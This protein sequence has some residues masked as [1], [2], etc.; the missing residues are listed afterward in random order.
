M[1]ATNKQILLLF[2]EELME[3]E[4]DSTTYLIGLSVS[5]WPHRYSELPCLH[6][7]GLLKGGLNYFAKHADSQSFEKITRLN[8]ASFEHVYAS[9]LPLWTSRSLR[10][11]IHRLINPRLDCRAFTGRGCLVL[12]L[13][14]LSHPNDLSALAMM[15]GNSI[16]TISNYVRWGVLILSEAMED[17]PEASLTCSLEHLQILGEKAG[18]TYG[19]VMRGCCIVTDGSLHPLERDADAQWAYLDYDHDHPDYNGWKSCYCKKGLYFFAIDG[20]IVWSCIDCPGRWHDGLI[21]DRSAS[22]LQALPAGLWV[23][24]DS[25]FPRIAGK[26]ARSRKRNEH[27]PEDIAS[28]QWQLQLEAHC[29][30]MRISSEW[31]IKGMKNVWRRL[32]VPFPSDDGLMRRATWKLSMQL[33]NYRGR[34]MG[35]GQMLSVFL[36]DNFISGE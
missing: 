28:A 7:T 5:N 21:F 11:N 9:F 15:N 30:K 27:L 35:M 24:G 34:S 20:T 8:L 36:Q 4:K 22:F 32:K 12:V 3:D 1:M 14:W 6:V 29:G 31:G 18:D 26:V 23:L 19:E 13:Y 25:A 33:H 17:I 2:L 16:G 10:G